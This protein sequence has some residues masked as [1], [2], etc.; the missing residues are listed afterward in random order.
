MSISMIFPRVIVKPN[1]TRGRPPGAHTALIAPFTSASGAN[2]ARPL[3]V[4]ATARRTVDLPRR[5]HFHV[6]AVGS[7]HDVWVEHREKRLE[8]TLA[9]GGQEGVDDFSLAGAIGVG[10]R[11][12]PLHPAA[13]AAGELPGRGRGAPHDGSDLVGSRRRSCRS[14]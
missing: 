1:T 9:R 2:R 5:A 14:G 11:G 6:C 7:E 13:R 10:S 3:K 4:S 12:R 8:V